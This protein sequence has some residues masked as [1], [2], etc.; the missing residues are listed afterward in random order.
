LTFLAKATYAEF[1]AADF[2]GELVG[3]TTTRDARATSLGDRARATEHGEREIVDEFGHFRGFRF[4]IHIVTLTDLG[5]LSTII[6]PLC[7]AWI[8]LHGRAYAKS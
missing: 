3:A 7:L 1:T 6:F 2:V 4:F 8:L 5:R